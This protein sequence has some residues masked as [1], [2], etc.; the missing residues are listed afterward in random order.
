[1]SSFAVS[2]FIATRMSISFLRATYPCLLARIV[3]QVGR[4]AMFDGKRFLPLTGI[5]IPKML[6][7]KTLFADCEPEPLTV[8]TWMLKSLTIGFAGVGTVACG[9]PR[10]F[11]AEPLCKAIFPVAIWRTSLQRRMGTGKLCGIDP[12]YS[13]K[14]SQPHPP[15]SARVTG[16][17]AIETPLVTWR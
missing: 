11:A 9:L 15:K 13:L 8:A 4:P 7:S 2:G 12:S 5:P 16:T 1:M 6:L 17:E 14:Y 10:A 3:Y